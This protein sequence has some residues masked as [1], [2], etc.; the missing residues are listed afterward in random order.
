MASHC[1]RH[2]QKR[3]PPRS[4]PRSRPPAGVS[5]GG[6]RYTAAPFCP[7]PTSRSLARHCRHTGVRCRCAYLNVPVF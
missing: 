5:H 2:Q 6:A 1:P 7:G 3:C 4:R